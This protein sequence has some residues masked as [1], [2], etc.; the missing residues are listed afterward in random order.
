[1]YKRGRE[2]TNFVHKEREHSRREHK[3]IVHKEKQTPIIPARRSDHGGPG[4]IGPGPSVVCL[5]L[6]RMIV[7]RTSG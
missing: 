3:E 4:L 1:M 7:L 6:R 2:R 5:E